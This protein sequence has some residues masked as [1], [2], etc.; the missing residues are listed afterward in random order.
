MA[1]YKVGSVAVYE[2]LAQVQGEMN[3]FRGNMETILEILQTHRAPAFTTAN[4]TQAAGVTN[5]TAAVGATVET[6]TETVVPTTVNR[7]L[8]PANVNKLAAAYPRGMPPNFAAYFANGSAFFP[9]PILTT[10]AAAGNI[11]FSEVSPPSILLWLMLPT[12][13][14]T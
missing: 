13:R 3:L 1:D 6:P 9:H 8:V 7:Q 12:P 11:V 2:S 14:T 4:V 10:P 5:P